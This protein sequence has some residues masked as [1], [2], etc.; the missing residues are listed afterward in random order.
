MKSPEMVPQVYEL[1]CKKGGPV[2]QW[3]IDGLLNH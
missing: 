2:E 1:W 3:G